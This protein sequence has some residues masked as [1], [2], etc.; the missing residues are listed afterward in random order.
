L[1]GRDFEHTRIHVELCCGRYLS[2]LLYHLQADRA[3]RAL[4]V[5]IED[6][7]AIKARIHKID[8]AKIHIRLQQR[9]VVLGKRHLWFRGARPDCRHTAHRRQGAGKTHPP[10]V[11]QVMQAFQQQAVVQQ[12]NFQENYQAAPQ[13]PL[14]EEPVLVVG[15]VINQHE[16]QTVVEFQLSMGQNIRIQMAQHVVQVMVTLLNKL[17]ESAQWGVG[18]DVVLDSP[19]SSDVLQVLH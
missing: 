10:Q 8:E 14:G 19:V 16:A 12:A 13:K 5:D 17:Q 3:A 7:D 15:L 4:A 11:A 18:L 1:Q 9:A 2:S 6:W